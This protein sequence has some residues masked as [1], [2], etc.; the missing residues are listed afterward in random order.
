MAS[1]ND[2]HMRSRI[3]AKAIPHWKAFRDGRQGDR[4]QGKRM[5][6]RHP[7]KLLK[8]ILILGN[9]AVRK[10]C[11]PKSAFAFRIRDLPALRQYAAGVRD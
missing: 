9:G 7:E 1:G 4:T 8:V 10:L 5:K 11:F 6:S 3:I 2:S